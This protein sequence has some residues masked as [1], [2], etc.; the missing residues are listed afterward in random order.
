MNENQARMWTTIFGGITALGL[1]AGG[2]YTIVEYFDSKEKDRTALS[3][4]IANATLAAKQSFHDKHLSLCID[5]T[6]ASATL[7]T[8]QDPAKK[9]MAEDEFWR[10]YWGPLAVVEE[11][12][13]ARAMVA[14]GACL[15]GNCSKDKESLAIDIAHACRTEVSR[16]FQ[17]DL[18]TV[19][20]RPPAD[21]SRAPR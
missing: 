20:D 12:E 5:A 4:Q 1:I 18:P 14:F 19:P 10:L 2:I 13:V 9:K 21:N 6:G 3:M 17:L 8:S 7:A 11:N 16:D 15:K